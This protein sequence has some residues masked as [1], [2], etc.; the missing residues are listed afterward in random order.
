MLFAQDSPI[1]DLPAASD[2]IIPTIGTSLLV[3]LA[4]SF[5]LWCLIRANIARSFARIL[6][7]LAI[8]AGIGVLT[9]GICALSMGITI[10]APFG[11]EYVIS[12]P[13]EAIGWGAGLLGGGITAMVLSLVSR[14]S[15]LP[16]PPT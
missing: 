9:W 12:D 11:L 10:R 8:G 1:P 13:I 15:R 3:I 5:V 7:V 4:F 16:M 14:S 2:P 6:A